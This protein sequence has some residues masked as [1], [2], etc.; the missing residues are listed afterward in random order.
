MPS[1]QY[2]RARSIPAALLAT[3]LGLA[4]LLTACG[5]GYDPLVVGVKEGAVR[6]T[7][8]ATVRQFLGIPYAAPPVGALRWK[9]P[10]APAPWDGVRDA[11]S[12]GNH[13]PQNDTTPLKYGYPGGKEDCLYLNVFTPKTPGKHPVMVWVHGGAFVL[14]RSN[15]YPVTRLVEQG[16]T[17]VT[18]NYRLGALGYLA[19]PALADTAGRSGN[20]GFLD[21]VAALKWVQSNIAAFGGDP[22]NVTLAGQSAGGLSVFAQLASPLAAGLFHKAVIQSSPGLTL[23]NQA[24]AHAL[25]A[26]TAQSSFGCANDAKAAECLRALP[27]DTVLAKQPGSFSQVNQPVVDGSFLAQNMSSAVASGQF[28]KMPVMVGSTHDEFTTFLG[29]TELTSGVPLSAAAYPFA[30]LNAFKVKAVADLAASLYPPGAYPSPSLAYSAAMADSVFACPTRRSAKQFQAAGVP[31]YAYEF[32]DANAPMTLQPPVSFPYKAYHAS[33]IQYLFD[34]PGTTL[35]PAQQQLSDAMVGNW[36][37]FMAT[38]N[39][40][41]AGSS[42]WP[43]YAAD[44][45]TQQFVP[46]ASGVIRNFAVNHKCAVWTPGV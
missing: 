2:R 4:L 12:F 37:R 43:L 13:C 28:N 24:E 29:Q 6:G 46:S 9:A 34:I 36:S 25:G 45:A 23:L 40:N 30:L 3:A 11:R 32:N 14:G 20:Y 35:S 15:N 41:A 22:A 26:T 44:E 5:G 16:N 33:E 10:V 8:T 17:V 31:V 39:P 21:Q 38:G 7:E 42:A 27:V 19:H 18:I 1:T